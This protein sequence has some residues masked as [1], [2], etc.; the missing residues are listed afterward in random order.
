MKL[1]ATFHGA[2]FH[3]QNLMLKHQLSP[4]MNNSYSS[5]FSSATAEHGIK[6]WKDRLFL[7]CSKPVDYPYSDTA[8]NHPLKSKTAQWL[9][10]FTIGGA[11]DALS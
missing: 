2:S 8:K 11:T 10:D 3:L 6:N 5:V 9:Y 7:I 4:S 1:P